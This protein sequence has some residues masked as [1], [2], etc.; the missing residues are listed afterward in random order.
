[1]NRFTSASSALLALGALLASGCYPYVPELKLCEDAVPEG[2]CPVGRGGTCDDASCKALYECVDATWKK[3]TTCAPFGGG[4]SGGVG[5]SGGGGGVG[6]AG[7]GGAGAGGAGAGGAGGA[8]STGG[9]GGC[10]PSALDHTGETT[11]C[12]PD[13]QSPDCPAAAAEPC[14][15]TACQTGCVDFYVCREDASGKAWVTVGYC[16]DT[17]HLIA[18]PP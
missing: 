9:A 6:G 7:A 10:T 11:G 5:G 4:G 14:A 16:D 15:E 17:G 18:S 13:L 1:M 3:S 12:T 8:T 2:G